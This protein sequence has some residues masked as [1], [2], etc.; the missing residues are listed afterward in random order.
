VFFGGATADATPDIILNGEK[1]SDLFG[2]AVAGAGDTNKDGFSDLVVGATL[3]DQAGSIAGKAYIYDAYRYEL[4]APLGGETWQVGSRQTVA[5]LGRDLADVWLSIDG[6][7]THVRLEQAV[8]GDA[9]NRVTILVPHVPTTFARVRITPSNPVLQGLVQS[10][11]LFTITTEIALLTFT[12]SAS[13]GGGLDL[14]WSTEP[15]VE[16]GGLAG[17]RLY[18][19]QDGANDVLLGA[20]ITTGTTFYDPDGVPGT[21]YRLVAVNGLGGESEIG[22]ARA[23]PGRG[24]GLDVW[25]QPYAGGTME[26]RITLSPVSPSAAASI[27]VFDIAG[28]S[29]RSL[30]TRSLSPTTQAATWDGRNRS[31]RT[32][33]NGLYFLR[34]HVGGQ[35]IQRKLIIAR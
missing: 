23:A 29:V 31:D 16:P 24:V 3:N 18:R 11:S 8:G 30:S 20:G 12:V 17:Y 7:A 34:A 6:G 26:I 25:P 33:S 35:V 32:V 19:Q 9:S 15:T 4:L 10:D 27:E 21:R 28:R 5:W 1:D 13:A 22:Y 14:A 2:D